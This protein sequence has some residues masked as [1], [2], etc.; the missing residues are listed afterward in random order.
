M[1]RRLGFFSPSP[2]FSAV[3]FSSHLHRTTILLQRRNASR[4]PSLP[5][6]DSSHLIL[7]Y[8]NRLHRPLFSFSPPSIGLHTIS[9]A[10]F[11]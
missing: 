3:A 8:C 7:F 4:W 10:L 2:V 11:A 1:R 6:N 5:Y 9:V